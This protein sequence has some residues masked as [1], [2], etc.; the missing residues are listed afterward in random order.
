MRRTLNSA[1]V[2]ASGSVGF[3]VE[4]FAGG[5]M[6]RATSAKDATNSTAAAEQ[7]LQVQESTQSTCCRL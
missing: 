6:A 2:R 7:Y 1:H 5:G 4:F 3:D